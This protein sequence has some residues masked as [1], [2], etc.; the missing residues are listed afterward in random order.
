MQLPTEMI[1]FH[2]INEHLMGEDD[3]IVAGS[4]ALRER[5]RQGRCGLAHHKDTRGS[6]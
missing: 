4:K 3:L 6:G 1:V 2:F 5:D